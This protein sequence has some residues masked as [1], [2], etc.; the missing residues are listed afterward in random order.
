M[1][2]D[3]NVENILI[4]PVVVASSL[5]MVALGGKASTASQVKTVLSANK[6]KDEHLHAGLSELLSEVMI[7]L[8]SQNWRDR[9]LFKVFFICPG[10]YAPQLSDA[11]KRNTTWKINNRLYGP[12]SV[13]F[14]DEFV[15]S[16]KK[17]YNYDHSK[18][19]FRDKRSAVNSIN[20]WAAKATD[21]KLP[22]ITK[23]VQNPDGA[24]IVNAMFFKREYRPLSFERESVLEDSELILPCPLFLSTAHWEE[25]FH[26]KMVDTRG[27][28]VSRS[29]TIGISMMHRTGQFAKLFEVLLWTSHFKQEYA[30]ATS[31][32]SEMQQRMNKLSFVLHTHL[33]LDNRKVLRWSRDMDS[34]RNLTLI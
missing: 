23:D 18:I 21:G 34:P 9:A 22:E 26:D 28:L 19:N 13:S 10:F 3:K 15:K 6:L 32:C 27:F 30:M 24:M 4:S 14:S 33:H 17:H 31:N 8:R 25:R 2:K 29:H 16:S 20:E 11:N 5:G 12:S 1:A 7:L